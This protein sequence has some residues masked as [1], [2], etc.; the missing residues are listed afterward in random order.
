MTELYYFSNWIHGYC[1]KG[2]LHRESGE[3]ERV[4]MIVKFLYIYCK[5]KYAV[6]VQVQSIWE[7]VDMVTMVYAKFGWKCEISSS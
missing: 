6:V 4:P 3:R 2:A 5:V 1:E 7:V